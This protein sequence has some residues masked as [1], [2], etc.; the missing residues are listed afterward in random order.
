MKI[1]KVL[2]VLM[3]LVLMADGYAQTIQLGYNG[4]VAIHPGIESRLT[5]NLKDSL[6]AK[7]FRLFVGPSIT[8]FAQQDVHRSLLYQGVVGVRK[9]GKT[10][11]A[12]FL[13]LGFLSESELIEGTIDLGSGNRLSEDRLVRNFF[14]P[15]LGY[16][17]SRHINPKLG[18][19]T[20]SSFGY[21]YSGTS[22]RRMV[23]FI[24]F[25]IQYYLK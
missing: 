19:Y 16:E 12:L 7:N 5:F 14:V 1:T 9:P 17:L 2:L 4:H 15:Q 6:S 13:G 11:H 3:L 10:S 20:R 25:G 22:Q 23:L 21:R 8:Y 18:W 24:G